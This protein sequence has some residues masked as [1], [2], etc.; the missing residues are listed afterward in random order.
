MKRCLVCDLPF[1]GTAW[2][3]PRCAREPALCDGIRVFAPDP[4]PE[5]ARYLDHAFAFLAGVEDRHF[6]F[7]SRNRLIAWTLARDCPKAV[8]L[9]EIGCGTGYVLNGIRRACPGLTLAGGDLF[10]SALAIAAGRL[11]GVAL[12]QMDARRIPFEAE[13]D[14]IGA[15]DMLEH[16]AEEDAVLAEARRA[17]RPGGHLLLTVPQHPGLWSYADDVAR[18]LRRYRARGLRARLERAGFRVRR[19]LPFV[20]LLAPALWAARRRGG[21]ER[22]LKAQLQLPVWANR[23]LAGVMALEFGLLRSG[24]RPPCGGSLLAVACKDAP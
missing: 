21:T 7:R 22:D 4:D 10:R 5:S 8:S 11:P 2:R 12:Y 1:G 20:A 15:F 13:F 3:C 17:L 14:V 16:V 24:W 23:A 9:L 18:H 6:W 19:C